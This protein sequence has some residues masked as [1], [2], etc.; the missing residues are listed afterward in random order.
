VKSS[1]F[2]AAT[3][4]NL[5][6]TRQQ[7]A[8]ECPP[9]TRL[10]RLEK[11]LLR[12]LALSAASG[13]LSPLSAEENG[14][15]RI[16]RGSRIYAEK[17]AMCHLPSGQGAPPVYPPLAGS[18]WLQKDRTRVIKVLCEG[19]S[20]AITV[21]G[22][23]YV[24]IMPAQMLDD[25]QVADVLSFIGASWGNKLEPFTPAEVTGARAQSKFPTYEALLQASSFQPL[26]EPPSG[27]KIRELAKLPEFCTRLISDGT[28]GKVY[29][30]GAHGTIYGVDIAAGAVW[31][32]IPESDYLDPAQRGRSALGATLDPEGRLLV[33]TNHLDESNP[34]AYENQVV[35]WRSTQVANGHPTGLKPWFTTHYPRGSKFEHGVSHMAFGPDGMLYVSSGSRTDAGEDTPAPHYLGGGEAQNTASLWRINPGAAQPAVEI[36]ARGLRNAYGFAW[37]G[38][39]RLFTVSNG[40]DYS[41]PEELDL[42]QPNRHYGFPYQFADW[43]AKPGFPYAHTP[44]APPGVE[45][46]Q[47]VPNIGPD[48]GGSPEKPMATFDPHSSPCGMLWCGP[49]YPAPFGNGFIMTR[50]GNL[51]GPPLAPED[52]GFDV[53]ALRLQTNSV[54]KLQVSTRRILAPLGRP[55]DVVQAGKN[56]LLILEYTRSTNFKDKVAWLP[57]RILELSPSGQ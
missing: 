49:E 56:R 15:L 41:A 43:P 5:A 53:L 46:T 11:V 52:V 39:G 24:N 13:F 42:I 20:G 9:E 50:S 27:W 10:L 8:S 30:L 35:F 44:A 1:P 25:G 26:P 17:C 23:H 48:G 18:D 28:G 21:N 32:L 4:K 34:E 7:P 2:H 31:P 51:L 6:R 19:L 12:L 55:I 14:E 40:P 47:P 22:V 54:G 45:F 29:A 33:V 16:E 37:D 36:Y 3:P 57:G 38:D